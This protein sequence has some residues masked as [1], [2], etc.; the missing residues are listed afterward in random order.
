MEANLVHSADLA[1]V[2]ENKKD[3]E[4]TFG[5]SIDNSKKIPAF[6]KKIKSKEIKSK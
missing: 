3:M 2:R 5:S 6:L 1:D 4:S